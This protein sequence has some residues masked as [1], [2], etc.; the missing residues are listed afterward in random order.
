MSGVRRNE[1]RTGTNTAGHAAI[2]TATNAGSWRSDKTTR[3]R[4]HSGNNNA[5]AESCGASGNTANK[6]DRAAGSYCATGTNAVTDASRRQRTRR[7][8]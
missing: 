2:N 3:N 7:I 4:T 8:Q 6:S 1:C 5:S